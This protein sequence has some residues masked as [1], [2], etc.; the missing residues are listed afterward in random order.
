[1]AVVKCD[2]EPKSFTT[3]LNVCLY[4]TVFSFKIPN[5]DVRIMAFFSRKLGEMEIQAEYVITI[6]YF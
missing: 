6:D 2:A 4:S 5:E 3:L 1:M